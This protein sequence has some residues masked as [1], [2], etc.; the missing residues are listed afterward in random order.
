MA[1]GSLTNCF[2]CHSV[3]P[4]GQSAKWDIGQISALKLAP[5]EK[6]D[7][8]VATRKYDQALAFAE[9]IL[10][11]PDFQLKQAFEFEAFAAALL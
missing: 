4:P 3:T 11:D 5:L 10:K 1:K 9:S 8:L 6:T 7:L 2:Q